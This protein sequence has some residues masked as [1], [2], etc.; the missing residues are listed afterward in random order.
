MKIRV[1]RAS[2]STNR[3]GVAKEKEGTRKIQRIQ[4]TE[5][6]YIVPNKLLLNIEVE[7]VENF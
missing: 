6:K 7:N 4:I 2:K 5:L 3:F 1:G